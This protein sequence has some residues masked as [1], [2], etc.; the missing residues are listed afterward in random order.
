[1]SDNEHDFE[2]NCRHGGCKRR[3]TLSTI[4]SEVGLF[5][6]FFDDIES[7]SIELA[8][9]DEVLLFCFSFPRFFL[10]DNVSVV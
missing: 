4:N 8:K 10:R 9:L 7:C 5:D 1:M 2:A 6:D 3:K